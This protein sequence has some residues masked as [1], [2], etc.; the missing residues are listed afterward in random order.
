M[1]PM[2][3][4][5]QFLV[6]L[7]F[8]GGISIGPH[9]PSQGGQEPLG[10][11]LRP[12]V[13][14]VYGSGG[15]EQPPWTIDSV[16]RDVALGGRTGCA[17]V[18][19]RMRPDQASAPPRTMCRGGD[20]LYSWNATANEWR[21]DRPLGAGMQLAVRQASG[22]TL[23]YVTSE[24]GDTTISGRSWPFVRTTVITR[25]PQG[26]AIRRLRERYAISLATALGGTF[27]VP[28]S[29]ASGGWR[30]SQRFDL[31]RIDSP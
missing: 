25:D 4:A 17:R 13:R 14:L 2:P 9:A 28:D 20:T 22:S 27:E 10:R 1:P 26:R 5:G 11:A 18:F 6:A 7:V 24:R 29:T 31:V 3:I 21:A 30:E 16:H 12:G 15:Q 19:L 8:L 23:E